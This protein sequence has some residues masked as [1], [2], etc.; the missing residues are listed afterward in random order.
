M[1]TGIVQGLGE[2][3]AIRKSGGESRFS[4]IPQFAMPDIADGESI[5]IN[6]ACLSVETHDRQGFS[7]YASAQTIEHTNLGLLAAGSLVNM[8]RALIF[9]ERMGGH[10]VSGHVD[11]VATVE[12]II[13]ARESLICRVSFPDSF[14]VCVIDRGSVALNGIS[15]TVIKRGKG[16]L[17]V[18]VIPDSQKRTN[19]RFWRQGTKINMEA[20]LVGKYVLNYAENWFGAEKPEKNAQAASA[21]SLDFLGRHGFL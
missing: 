11:C 8:E 5:A 15:L 7:A 4:F 17:E 6:G 9:G 18:N 13:Q 19:M 14:S 21:L 3:A 10:L 20:D 1:F 16:F 12:K 2:V